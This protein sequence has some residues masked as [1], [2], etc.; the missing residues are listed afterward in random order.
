MPSTSFL[1]RSTRPLSSSIIQN[2]LNTSD[3]EFPHE[4]GFLRIMDLAW[5]WRLPSI[6][7]ETTG[8]SYDVGSQPEHIVLGQGLTS[9]VTLHVLN[10]DDKAFAKSQDIIA[11]K[12]FTDTSATVKEQRHRVFTTIM[13]EIKI[14]CR[15]G[16]SGH[17][18]IAQL[19]CLVWEK[20][21]M[22]PGLAMECSTYGSLDQLIRGTWPGFND[23]QISSARWHITLDI[24][25]GLY[26]IHEAGITHGDLK[27]ENILLMN[28]GTHE[29]RV[30]AKL[31]DFGG[32]TELN[33]DGVNKPLHHTPLWS[34]PE[35]LHRDPDV[36]WMKADVY[37]FGLVIASLWLAPRVG[38]GFGIGRAG[39]I[40]CCVISSIVSSE[41]T[42]RDEEELL[43][44]LKSIPYGCFVDATMM[45]YLKK[46][47]DT[48]EVDE[49]DKMQLVEVLTPTLNA[50][51]WLRPDIKDVCLSLAKSADL[52]GRKVSK[53]M[54]HV[55]CG[56]LEDSDSP[57]LDEIFSRSQ[58]HVLVPVVVEHASKTLNNLRT[59][60]YDAIS[61]SGLEDLFRRSDTN[62]DDDAGEDPGS[63]VE[64][65]RR[66]KEAAKTVFLIP[67]PGESHDK[68]WHRLKTMNEASFLP[69]FIAAV[70]QITDPVSQK[71]RQTFEDMVCWAAMAGNGM[72]VC[73]ATLTVIGSSAEVRLPIPYF[74]V[75]LAVSGSF[76]A[77]Q[78]LFERYP[79]LFEA[80]Q[81]LIQA[82]PSAFGKFKPDFSQIVRF[83]E[84]YEKTLQVLVR[85]GGSTILTMQGV[86]E[87]SPLSIALRSEDMIATGIFL[88]ALK[89]D[90]EALTSYL[91]SESSRNGEDAATVLA[92][93]FDSRTN[94]TFDL[95]LQT[96]PTLVESLKGE[97]GGELIQFLCSANLRCAQT[98]L[99][100]CPNLK[101]SN[102]NRPLSILLINGNMEGV[103]SVVE[104][105]SVTEIKEIVARHPTDGTSLCFSILAKTP[106]SAGSVQALHWLAEQGGIHLYGP[107]EVPAWFQ[108]VG[109]VRPNTA[110]EQR[111]DARLLSLLL[112]R[113]DREEIPTLDE[114]ENEDIMTHAARNG[115]LEIVR[116]LL[117]K[118]IDI[119]K[120]TL[121]DS[122][123]S[124]CEPPS[125]SGS[126]EQKKYIIRPLDIVLSMLGGAEVP[127]TVNQGGFLAVQKWTE[128]LEQIADLLIDR[129]AKSMLIEKYQESMQQGRHF[130]ENSIALSTFARFGQPMKGIWPA[131]LPQPLSSPTGSHE[132]MEDTEPAW[133]Q[134]EVV[135]EMIA[136][137][138]RFFYRQNARNNVGKMNTSEIRRL[139]LEE[140]KDRARRMKA[141]WRLPPDWQCFAFCDDEQVQHDVDGLYMNNRT[142]QISSKKPRL[143]RGG[144]ILEEDATGNI[145][146]KTPEEG[147]SPPE[148]EMLFEEMAFFMSNRNRN[149]GSSPPSL[150]TV[151]AKIMSHLGRDQNSE[152]DDFKEIVSDFMRHVKAEI[153]VRQLGTP[154]P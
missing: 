150:S 130:A 116:L 46:K 10:K 54:R 14:L 132:S 126:H 8:S 79:H 21:S 109:T 20:D 141:N 151:V 66:L 50:H 148:L 37:S 137:V 29:H 38:G 16:I 87:S 76:H 91:L 136:N 139:K 101:D 113:Q 53:E 58:L 57:Q 106:R 7:L 153:L 90:L 120:G 33:A 75:V 22:F 51:F 145:Q 65:L 94:Q 52:I 47:A 147:A 55:Q 89:Q 42:E 28:S 18:N 17:P 41:M 30:V 27:P 105:Y 74:L 35:I 152:S 128:D 78:I 80:S 97:K 26:A 12:R 40:S 19:H 82:K 125:E 143:Y 98:L 123:R 129:G 70:T 86:R 99:R 115:H 103:Y 107:S 117:S 146:E 48:E 3:D 102:G 32:A 6:A 84:A 133:T 73:L 4:L 45:D 64:T 62:S 2:L 83:F 63:P 131:P 142:L 119:N 134:Y 112:F 77:S 68:T 135:E 25:M 144:Q 96:F 95:L 44:Y 39:K 5:S 85:H 71:G 67:L 88:E 127:P 114:W 154:T 13:N 93:C 110:H 100:Y 9:K 60:T 140:A 118:N 1:S 81:K 56:N 61:A 15:P 121:V 122:H 59:P 24:S 111:I 31:T 49:A 69:V 72:G 138:K 36:D 124:K 11:I 92:D 43:L 104:Y 149:D 34:A 23:V 108:I